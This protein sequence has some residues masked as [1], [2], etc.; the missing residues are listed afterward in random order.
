M[1]ESAF[2]KI[3][4]GYSYQS[5]K[6]WADRGHKL[7]ATRSHVGRIPTFIQSGIDEG[8]INPI[9]VE[10]TNSK[11]VYEL[12]EFGLQYITALIEAKNL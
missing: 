11:T 6:D 2:I 4:S 7:S 9:P 3:F 1:K 12:T 5:L 10:K 8:Y